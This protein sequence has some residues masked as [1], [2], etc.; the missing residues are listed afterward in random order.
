MRNL[1]TI[2]HLGYLIDLPNCRQDQDDQDQS[3]DLNQAQ[4]YGHFGGLAMA[5][6]P[7]HEVDQEYQ[8]SFQR[9]APGSRGFIGSELTIFSIDNLDRFHGSPAFWIGY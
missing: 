4:H 5:D 6:P 8:H 7:P 1:E 9:T 3:Y 2:D